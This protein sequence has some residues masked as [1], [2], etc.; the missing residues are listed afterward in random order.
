MIRTI[1][2]GCFNTNYRICSQ[3]SF[4][5][6][7]LQTFFNCREVVLRYSTTNNNLFKYIWSF[8]IT[9]W[10]KTH[11]NVT[12]LSVS[13]GLFLMFTFH[14][15][16]LADSFTESNLWFGKFDVYFVALFQFADLP[17]RKGASVCWQNHLQHGASCLHL[18]FLQVPVQFCLHHLS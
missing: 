14:I 11:L 15:R 4:L 13:T 3:R 6:A 16:I 10:L 7:F 12:I 18:P 17:F 9:G 1:V 5:N 2:K 8:Q